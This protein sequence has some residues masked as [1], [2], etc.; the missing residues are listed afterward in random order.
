MDNNPSTWET[1]AHGKPVRRP[2]SLTP[3]PVDLVIIA[4]LAG[5]TAISAQLA[6]MGFTS[7]TDFVH[8]LDAVKVGGTT[9]QLS[10]P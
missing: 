3:H 2:D 9:L 1:T 10:L 6:L 5:S 7:R 8:F 4:S